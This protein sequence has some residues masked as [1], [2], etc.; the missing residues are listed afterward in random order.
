MNG[1]DKNGIHEVTK[2]VFDQ[3][4]FDRDG[5]NSGGFDH[6]GFDHDGFDRD[7]HDKYGFNLDEIHKVTGTKYNE[8]GFKKK[9]ALSK[10][11]RELARDEMQNES[12]DVREVESLGKE[13]SRKEVAG[14]KNQT[15][16]L[17]DEH[18]KM[19]NKFIPSR[20]ANIHE[21]LTRPIELMLA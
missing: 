17:S 3:G 8:I 1:F 7:G 18:K 12:E 14:E 6:D 20:F 21:F 10:F 11:Q 19:I 13:I 2:G 9:G 16:E 5:Y 15:I 4:G